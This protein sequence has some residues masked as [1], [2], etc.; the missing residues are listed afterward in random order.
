M[1]MTSCHEF[2]VFVDYREFTSHS[3]EYLRK[4]QSDIID[5]MDRYECMFNYKIEKRVHLF[6][7][8]FKAIVKFRSMEKRKVFSHL[9]ET[10][11]LY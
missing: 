8:A 7:G 10:V 11:S 9:F 5:N 6:D 4:N 2:I 1:I 3:R